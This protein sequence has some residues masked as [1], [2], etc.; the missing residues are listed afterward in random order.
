MRSDSAPA[1][2]IEAEVR[3]AC[4][5]SDQQDGRPIPPPSATRTLPRFLDQRLDEGIELPMCDGIA[6]SRWARWGGDGHCCL[7]N[8]IEL[9]LL[10]P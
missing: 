7:D 6:W 8:K 2:V 3:E 4:G 5:K 10:S 1:G 9:V